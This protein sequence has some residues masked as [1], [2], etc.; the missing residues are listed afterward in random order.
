MYIRPGVIEY[1][2]IYVL[3]IRSGVIHKVK[4]PQNLCANFKG[5]RTRDESKSPGFYTSAYG[6]SCNCIFVGLTLSSF[7]LCRFFGIP[8]CLGDA[9]NRKRKQRSENKADKIEN[10]VNCR[11]QKL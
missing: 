1:I 5:L 11:T 6:S 3:Y 4:V 9:G 7:L 2:C 10:W 8:S